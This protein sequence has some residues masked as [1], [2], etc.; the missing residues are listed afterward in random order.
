MTLPSP[1]PQPQDT[2]APA[3]WDA[4]SP[5]GT[6]PP[7]SYQP[8][9]AAPTCPDEGAWRAWLDADAAGL[10]P[11]TRLAHERHH[12]QCAHCQAR[13]SDLRGAAA[14]TT[15]ALDRL[16]GPIALLSPA[17]TAVARQRLDWRRRAARLAAPSPVAAQ[18]AP[19]PQSSPR[20][21][22]VIQSLSETAARWRVALAGL[23]AALLLTFVIGFTPRGQAAASSFL[24]QFRGEKVQIIPLSASTLQSADRLFAQLAHLGTVQRPDGLGA[25]LSGEAAARATSELRTTAE[26]SQKLG[27]PVKTPGVLP[28]GVSPTPTI[29]YLPGQTG[30]FTFDEARARAY[31]QSTG[32]PNVQLPA[33]FDGATLVVNLPA[34]V[35]LHYPSATASLPASAGSKSGLEAASGLLVGQAGPLTV[36][37]VSAQ[38][39]TLDELRDFLLGLP[40]MPAE[41]KAQLRTIQDW[42]T[43]LPLPIPVDKVSWQQTRIAGVEGLILN[44]NSGLGSGALFQQDGRLYGVAGGFKA[45]EIRRVAD[46]LS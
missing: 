3:A 12:Q 15:V 19:A 10:D 23:A 44:D 43:T 41:L 29:R 46:S 31:F 20:E 18:G 25:S 26:A 32:Q 5:G 11:P 9:A 30:R 45:D 17:E 2:P 42:Q 21:P 34:A 27:F 4:R 36:E 38:G 8:A 6:R 13:L 24:A 1:P 39:V 40:G 16:A 28:A 35:L 7:L 22:R 37:V 33:R 14:A